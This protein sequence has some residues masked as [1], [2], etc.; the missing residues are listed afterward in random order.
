MTKKTF[1]KV[2]AA[3]VVVCMC[4]TVVF[5]GAVSAT[6]PIVANCTVKGYEYN[7][8]VT[9]EYVT[10][11]VT[12]SS[13]TDFTAGGF[14]VDCPS[15][16]TF[17][18]CSYAQ[19]VTGTVPQVYVNISGKKV[20]FAGFT[21]STTSDIVDFGEITLLLRFK[22]ETKNAGDNWNV[23]I[24]DISITNSNEDSYTCANASGKAHVHNFNGD[25]STNDGVTTTAC[26]VSG[27][28]AVKTTVESTS[29]ATEN[30]LATG[31]K[32][33]NITFAGDGD[34]VL[35][36]L[37]P[38]DT[39][40]AQSGTVYF[41]YRYSDG[42]NDT[43]AE[44]SITGT[45]TTVGGVQ[46]YAFP[47]GRNA[48][49][50]RMARDIKGNFVVVNGDNVTK[51]KEWSYSV[52]QCLED[53][54]STGDTN[55]KNYAKALWNYGYYTT[56]K[57]YNDTGFFKAELDKFTGGEKTPTGSYSLP[58][59]SKSTY[60]GTDTSWKVSKISV[61]TGYTPKINFTLNKSVSSVTFKL[62]SDT[63]KTALVYSK[64]IDVNGTTFTIT[65]I[66][67]KYLKGEIEVTV[68]DSDRVFE[69]SIGRYATARASKT[70]GN[71]FKWMVNYSY[72][73]GVAFD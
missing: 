52:K 8:G 67:A 46:Y 13:G 23:S 9:D 58:S 71:I 59:E 1:S 32:Y 27:C 14:T 66:P 7:P 56:Q 3:V 19:G 68:S 40:E 42:E 5:T 72:Y 21:E 57:L 2:I 48:G 26:T 17:V 50:G 70:D 54:I 18:A 25:P 45:L 53:L 6:D 64:E 47:C 73:L 65:D 4:L 69:Y 11:E 51:S 29:A 39:Y 16:L 41:A 24:K 60:T 15:T 12:F 31:D 33:A 38:K 55:A 36:A 44:A 35:N 62:Y 28:T 20:I 37:L 61:T 22:P 43:P 34:V 30:E 10:Y 63:D 49:I